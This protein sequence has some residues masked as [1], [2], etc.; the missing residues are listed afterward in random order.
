MP[1]KTPHVS[2]SD[3]PT[4]AIFRFHE[5]TQ[6]SE[7]RKWLAS[8]RRYTSVEL[9]PP[10]PHDGE[11]RITPSVVLC[12]SASGATVKKV[13]VAKDGVGLWRQVVAMA[14]LVAAERP[15]KPRKPRRR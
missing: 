14:V 1:P 7:V 2:R 15:P 3:K 6:L 9:V 4:T 5:R 13:V 8:G 11:E 10:D 12:R